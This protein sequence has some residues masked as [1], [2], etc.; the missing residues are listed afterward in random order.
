MGVR[1]RLTWEPWADEAA[2]W[3]RSSA[4]VDLGAVEDA[5]RAGLSLQAE[6]DLMTR[7]LLPG[8]HLRLTLEYRHEDLLAGLYGGD[9]AGA[10]QLAGV[11][12]E[13]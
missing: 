6:L 7:D 1:S 12:L 13:F 4:E 11:R 2:T 5:W 8:R 9:V 3:F 10:G